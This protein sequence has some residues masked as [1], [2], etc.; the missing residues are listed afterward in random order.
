MAMT[1]ALGAASPSAR[2]TARRPQGAL[3][4]PVIDFLCLGG[5]SLLC[6]PLLALLRPDDF[7]AKSLWTVGF[8]AALLINQPHFA[9]SYQIFYRDFARKAFGRDA[10]AGLRVRYVIAGLVVPVLLVSYFAIT[11]LD[12]NAVALGYAANFMLF[13]VGWHYVKQGYGMIIVDSVLK[14]QFFGAGEKRVLLANSYACWISY[15]L[16]ANWAVAEND[17]FGLKYYMLAVPETVLF[18]S[19]AVTALTSAATVAMLARKFRTCGGRLP[20]NGVAAYVAALYPWL[21]LRVDPFFL[22]CLPTFHSLQ[23][24]IVVWRYQL[25]IAA[26][27][28]GPERKPATAAGQVRDVRPYARLAGF[29]LGGIGLGV[30][31]F[32][33]VPSILDTVVAY[34][35]AV[36]GGTLFV[37]L[38]WIFINVHH[39]FLDNVMW[40]RA[41]PE[42]AKY[43]FQAG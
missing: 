5:G 6:L 37:G 17:I 35:R 2:E 15:W 18:G 40:R 23:Y 36:F 31:G 12:G 22:F 4:H 7:S 30:L 16:F 13:V 19:A 32:W 28:M 20:V 29:A 39:Y 1:S 38:F 43:L 33:L 25:N 41:N 10:D 8:L 9:H 21:F 24:L 42:V 14:R 26:D 34:D 3:F 27:R 11:I